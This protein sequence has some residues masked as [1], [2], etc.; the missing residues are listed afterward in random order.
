MLMKSNCACRLAEKVN[1]Y[2]QTSLS[3]DAFNLYPNLA[4]PPLACNVL[5]LPSSAL[6]SPR[7]SSHTLTVTPLFP[8]LSQCKNATQA[9]LAFHNFR[10]VKSLSPRPLE[11]ALPDENG[12]DERAGGEHEGDTCW[13]VSVGLEL[14]PRGLR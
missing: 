14:G 9:S 3:Q 4:L 7:L 2:L 10:P 6:T 12:Q 8:V 11:R 1:N 5:C 13:E